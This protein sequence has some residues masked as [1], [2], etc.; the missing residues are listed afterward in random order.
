M[1][2]GVRNTFHPNRDGTFTL[3]TTQDAEPILE[4][5]RLWQGE[6]QTGDG[7]RRIASIP[8]VTWMQWLQETN[9]DLERMD[10]ATL[11]KFIK[12]KLADPSNA[13]L[14]TI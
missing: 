12:R 4:N 13:F 6:R 8:A 10:K 2:D 9:G 11:A 1:S 5:N 7:L 3:Q 14:R